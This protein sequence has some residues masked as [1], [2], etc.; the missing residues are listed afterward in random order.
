LDEKGKPIAASENMRII[1]QADGSFVRVS[2]RPPEGPESVP[3]TIPGVRSAGAATR[4]LARK[5]M[6]ISI[7]KMN[8][9]LDKASKLA[10]E[11]GQFKASQYEAST[12]GIRMSNTEKVMT[13][14]DAEGFDRTTI[15]LSLLNKAPELIKSGR[16][17]RYVQAQR[18][19]INATLR[20]ESGAAIAQSEFDNAEAQ[21]FP[22]V[23]DP[24]ELLA[25]KKENRLVVQ[26]A[27][28]AEAGPAWGETMRHFDK[29]RGKKP[30]T[31]KKFI[32]VKPPS[33]S[34]QDLLDKYGIK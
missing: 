32:K 18:S 14:L 22:Q 24:P 23:N 6:G 34:D 13:G 10:L 25:Q 11:G 7:D 27:M 5:K 19:F 3:Q 4:A 28:R 12:Y 1:E 30:S 9:D 31:T 29:L 33:K 8:I 2:T 20:R 26:A 15:T 21:Y 17:K 16:L